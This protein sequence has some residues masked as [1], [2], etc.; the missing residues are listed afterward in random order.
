MGSDTFVLC[1]VCGKP[2]RADDF[3]A[4]LN[5]EFYHTKCYIKHLKDNDNGKESIKHPE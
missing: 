3:G 1:Q 4:I 2:I 5:G